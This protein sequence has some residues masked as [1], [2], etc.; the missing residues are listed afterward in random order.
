[1]LSHFAVDIKIETLGDIFGAAC[2]TYFYCI[3]ICCLLFLNIAV[4]KTVNEETAESR[5][6]RARG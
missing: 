3:D 1:M 4:L 2:G 6:S 5:L